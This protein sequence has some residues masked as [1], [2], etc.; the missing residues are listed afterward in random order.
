MRKI[1]THCKRGH[2]FTD[3]NTYLCPN[4]KRNCKECRRIA[5]RRWYD[6]HARVTERRRAKRWTV[7]SDG[8]W[9]WTGALDED[10]Y[11]RHRS[12]WTEF[13]GPVPSGMVLHHRC[14]TRS[15]VNPDH[16]ELITPSEHTL[17]H[18][19]LQPER[20]RLL[21][22]IKASKTHCPSGHPYS[23]DNL[24]YDSHSGARRCR[25]CTN[26]KTARYRAR[27]VQVTA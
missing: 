16:L 10:G 9:K 24:V 2:E 3:E 18:L 5:N 23:G 8:C 15:C 27:R 17:L 19:R 22:D 26:A 1:L 4:G 13:N 14:H 25:E 6:V 7:S 20:K 12:V 11:G 21:G